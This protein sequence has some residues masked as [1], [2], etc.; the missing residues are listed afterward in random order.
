[1]SC[2][3]MLTAIDRDDGPGDAARAVADQERS[4][5]ADVG[6]VYQWHC[7]GQPLAEFELW[8][9]IFPND[10]NQLRWLPLPS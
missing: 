5:S 1:M 3:C 9:V 4:E 6:D 8:R 10:Q 2:D 7:H